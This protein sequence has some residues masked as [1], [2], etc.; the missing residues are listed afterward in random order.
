M[1]L[2]GAFNATTYTQKKGRWDFRLMQS[3]IGL[4]TKS[5]ATLIPPQAPLERILVMGAAES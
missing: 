3:W 4:L 5:D 2:T 1:A